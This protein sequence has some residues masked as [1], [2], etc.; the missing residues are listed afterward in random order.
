[1][2][3]SDQIKALLKSH[4][5]G[6]NT[7]FIAVAAQVAAHEARLGHNKLAEELLSLIDAAKARQFLPSKPDKPIPITQPRG[8][9][10]G[11]LDVT[12]P[13]TRLSHMILD[14]QVS[15]KLARL[16]REQRHLV[17]IQEHGLDPRRKILL[18]GPPGTGKTMTASALAGELGIP[19]FLVRLD[20]LIT[21]YMGETAAKL[22]LVFDNIA[23]LRGVYFFDEFDAIGSQRGL[24]NDVGEIRRILNSFL[25]M[26]EQDG[27][28]SVIVAA[29][30][31]VEILDYALF[32]RFD[33]IVEYGL[34][35][36]E[37]IILTLRANLVNFNIH[38]LHWEQL[39]SMA[40]GLNYADIVRCAQDAIKHV[41]IHDGEVI[42]NDD[43]EKII[44]E[45]KASRFNSS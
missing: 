2:A 23:Q 34:P 7:R 22:R 21:K 9:L 39:A 25:Q 13:K 10:A 11:L 44:H 1:M 18:I 36:E 27:S 19:L 16:I 3:S 31:H 28:Q 17:K 5:E 35:N 45:R 8:E 33:D 42:M 20:A 32:R 26:L 15:E 29:T 37:Q 43:L 24:S 6:D 14:Q 4:L 38:D 40:V 12:Y 41:I 30:N